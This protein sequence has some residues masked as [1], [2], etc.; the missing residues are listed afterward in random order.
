MVITMVSLPDKLT[1]LMV[2][3]GLQLLLAFLSLSP[4]LFPRIP[5]YC[6]TVSHPLQSGSTSILESVWPP[7]CSSV[8][9]LTPSHPPP[10]SL[11]LMLLLS[12]KPFATMC[13]CSGHLHRS[14]MEG[15]HHLTAKEKRGLGPAAC[16]ELSASDSGGGVRPQSPLTLPVHTHKHNSGC[17]PPTPM[18]KE[19]LL[20]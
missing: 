19:Y 5:K 17:T 16:W 20:L 11:V 13:A 1:V 18:R 3:R 2:T 4:R 9:G 10:I 14:E 8:L 6:L 7:K 12:E 15:D